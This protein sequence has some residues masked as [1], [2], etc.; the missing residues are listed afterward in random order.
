M[1]VTPYEDVRFIPVDSTR[2][3]G[4]QIGVLWGDPAKGPWAML[5][6]LKKGSGRLH[7][8][9]SDYHL[10]LLQGTAKHWAEGQQEADAKPLGPGSFW[11]QP[12]NQVHGDSCLTDE[13]LM[14]VKWADK[15]DGMLAE[16]K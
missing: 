8:H 2:P 1:V 11:F 4:P 9:S 3:D 7:Y 15:R 5:L 13:C 16:P 10:V 12:G 14:F 6:K